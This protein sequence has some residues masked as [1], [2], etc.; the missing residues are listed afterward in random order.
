MGTEHHDDGEEPLVND[1]RRIDPETGEIR[2]PG[3]S[4]PED[5]A[6]EAEG[7]TPVIDEAELAELLAQASAGTVPDEEP[8]SVDAE[9]AEQ[10]LRDLQRINAE[11]ANYR[12]RTEQERAEAQ[13]VHTAAVLRELLPV[14]DDLDRAEQHGD[15]P[16][17]GPLGVIAA[18]LRGV[19]GRLG[20]SPYGEAGE[21]FDP[22]VHEAIARLPEPEA[23][24]ETIADVVERGYTV[25]ERVVRVAKVAVSVPAE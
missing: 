9:L 12:R 17:D 1:K 15:L 25:G 3:P 6:G 5:G 7:G 8:V 16:E 2:R 22:K 23:D 14:L 19:L 4:D 10:R 11:Y 20:L 18:K 24:G 21:A 13:E